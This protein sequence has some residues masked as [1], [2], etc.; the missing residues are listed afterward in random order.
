MR[1]SIWLKMFVEAYGMTDIVRND[2]SLEAAFRLHVLWFSI[3]PLTKETL[4]QKG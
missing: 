3:G 2:A 1:V 4:P